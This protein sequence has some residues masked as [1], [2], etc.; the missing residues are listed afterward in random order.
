MVLG[1]LA[2]SFW[3]RLCCF[4]PA[5]CLSLLSERCNKKCAIF[6]YEEVMHVFWVAMVCLMA[7]FYKRLAHFFAWYRSHRQFK[8]IQRSEPAIFTVED[9]EAA[10]V[11]ASPAHATNRHRLYDGEKIWSHVFGIGIGSY[12]LVRCTQFQT[13]HMIYACVVSWAL[14]LIIN[15]VDQIRLARASGS[16]GR[17]KWQ[18]GAFV[19]QILLVLSCA[20]GVIYD[21]VQGETSNQRLFNTPTTLIAAVTPFLYMNAATSHD[22]DGDVLTTSFPVT[23]IL[24]LCGLLAIGSTKGFDVMLYYILDNTFRSVNIFILSPLAALAMLHYTVELMRKKRMRLVVTS[25]ILVAAIQS[26]K[27]IPIAPALCA[28]LF[29]FWD[30]SPD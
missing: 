6:E 12:F 7:G 11:E 26:R 16:A 25:F 14:V 10:D 21:S 9:E 1:R 27:P 18:H 30:W 8:A 4:V 17:T 20:S 22:L 19:L 29:E 5:L 3:G 24:S 2:K 13:A 28:Y 23:V 15:Y